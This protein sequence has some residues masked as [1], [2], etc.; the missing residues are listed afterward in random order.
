M[1][2]EVKRWN[3]AEG[4][5]CELAPHGDS[6]DYVESDDYDTLLAERDELRGVLESFPGFLCGTATADAWVERKR[7]ALQES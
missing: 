3:A 7:K 1:S 4:G 6:G 2:K 5:G